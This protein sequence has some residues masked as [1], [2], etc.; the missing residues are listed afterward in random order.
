VTRIGDKHAIPDGEAECD[1]PDAYE[2]A[3]RWL[4][5]RLIALF[6]TVELVWWVIWGRP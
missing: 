6:Q 5:D 1:P 3:M 4:F 2:T